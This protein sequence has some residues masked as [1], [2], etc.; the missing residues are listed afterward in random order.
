MQSPAG[1]ARQTLCD[2][3]TSYR[4]R[5]RTQHQGGT[6]PQPQLNRQGVTRSCDALRTLTL[7]LGERPGQHHLSSSHHTLGRCPAE[8]TSWLS[9]QEQHAA[10]TVCLG[11]LPGSAHLNRREGR[12]AFSSVALVEYGSNL[13][14]QRTAPCTH[15]SEPASPGCAPATL[16][17]PWAWVQAPAGYTQ[18]VECALSTADQ[19][20]PPGPFLCSPLCLRGL[21]PLCQLP[22]A[23]LQP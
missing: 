20:F 8:R 14:M 4:F 23:S 7:Q 9:A 21:R 16:S 3:S 18:R 22:G 2:V 1:C 6:F 10:V 19:Q 5:V 13:P 15:S 17:A 12:Q 11:G